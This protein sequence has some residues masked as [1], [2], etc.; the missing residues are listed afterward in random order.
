MWKDSSKWSPRVHA[1]K[2]A[3]LHSIEREARN[4]LSKEPTMENWKH[5]PPFSQRTWLE[6]KFCHLFRLTPSLENVFFS[7][8]P[9]A[10]P[11]TSSNPPFHVAQSV[12]LINFQVFNRC[13]LFEKMSTFHA[14][15]KPKKPH[16]S[17]AEWAKISDCELRLSSFIMSK[18]RSSTLQ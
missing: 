13:D 8:S 4:D 12:N 9:S 11:K 10:S 14:T 16:R 2:H 15:L 17:S 5:L 18:L 7:C 1:I 3:K 6:G